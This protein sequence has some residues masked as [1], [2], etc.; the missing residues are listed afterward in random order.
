MIDATRKRWLANAG[1]NNRHGMLNSTLLDGQHLRSP[2]LI[3]LGVFA[4]SPGSLGQR[5]ICTQRDKERGRLENKRTLGP[6]QATT[7]SALAARANYVAMTR[8]E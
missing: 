5:R 4:V 7:Y 1:A 6:D 3:C 8:R 2:S